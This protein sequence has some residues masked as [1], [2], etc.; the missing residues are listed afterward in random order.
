MCSE[1]I[2][3][4]ILCFEYYCW[5]SFKKFFTRFVCFSLKMRR[6]YFRPQPNTGVVY[7][8]NSV[9]KKKKTWSGSSSRRY[10]FS[11]TFYPLLPCSWNKLPIKIV[12]LYSDTILSSI[13]YFNS[14]S[15]I[16]PIYNIFDIHLSTSRYKFYFYWPFFLQC[17]LQF[18]AQ[19]LSCNRNS[20]S[21]ITCGI[22]RGKKK[23][24]RV[25]YKNKWKATFYRETTTKL[26]YWVVLFYIMT[27]STAGVEF[28]FFFYFKNS[29][30]LGFIAEWLLRGWKGKWWPRTLS[31][32]STA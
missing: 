15:W 17:C 27:C 24:I 23:K 12:H 16:H 3:L 32:W 9:K 5:V 22:T 21:Y 2:L 10:A 30:L 26:W 1:Q 8:L 18:Y 28:Y 6:F 11:P 7:T 20:T 14:S 29:F 19:G 13:D 31:L 25:S 4:A